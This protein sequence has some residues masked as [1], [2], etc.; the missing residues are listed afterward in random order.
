MPAARH[1]ARAPAILLPEVL[2]VLLNLFIIDCSFELFIEVP[3]EKIIYIYYYYLLI[4][5]RLCGCSFCLL[6]IKKANSIKT[7]KPFSSMVRKVSCYV[8]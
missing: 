3:I 1:K 6:F 4:L 2:V 7:E 5:N 8:F